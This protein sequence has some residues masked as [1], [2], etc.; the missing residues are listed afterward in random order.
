MATANWAAYAGTDKVKPQC[1]C[2]GKSLCNTCYVDAQQRKA[3]RFAFGDILST[4]GNW[5][6]MSA[7]EH[8]ISEDRQ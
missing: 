7:H 8:R 5:Y 1:E 6:T 4:A 3:R 2:R